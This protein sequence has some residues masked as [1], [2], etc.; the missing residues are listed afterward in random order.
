MPKHLIGRNNFWKFEVLRGLSAAA[1]TDTRRR[2]GGPTRRRERSRESRGMPLPPR[3]PLFGCSSRRRGG[4]CGPRAAPTTTI[5]FTDRSGWVAVTTPNWFGIQFIHRFLRKKKYKNRDFVSDLGDGFVAPP[6]LT[7]HAT[8][9][10]RDGFRRR[11]RRGGGGAG[12]LRRR[13]RRLGAA[14]AA[15]SPAARAPRGD[16]LACNLRRP[17]LDV[18]WIDCSFLLESRCVALRL[19]IWFFFWVITSRKFR[20]S[21]RWFDARTNNYLCFVGILFDNVVLTTLL[22]LLQFS[23][24]FSPH[25][26]SKFY[27]NTVQ[28]IGKKIPEICAYNCLLGMGN[29]LFTYHIWVVFSIMLPAWWWL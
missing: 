9:R 13:G 16:F 25:P 23:Y 6:L 28:S 24:Q 4:G 5:I 7:P 10:P 11:R 21:T 2:G 3:H 15:E 14:A 26:T 8:P 27:G 18:G 17:A 19:Q 22:L 29:V 12:D 1:T 20:S